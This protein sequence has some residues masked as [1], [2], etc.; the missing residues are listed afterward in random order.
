MVPNLYPD[1]DFVPSFPWL[2]QRED[3][4]NIDDDIPSVDVEASKDNASLESPQ[5]DLTSD[6]DYQ[7][8]ELSST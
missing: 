8:S 2:G 3:E 1:P 5:N 4:D 6:M 7:S